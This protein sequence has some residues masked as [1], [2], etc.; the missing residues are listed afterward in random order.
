[1]VSSPLQLIINLNP[2]IHYEA[3]PL[4]IEYGSVTIMDVELPQ[5][6]IPLPTPRN[7]PLII[8]LLVRKE[9]AKK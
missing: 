3:N 5:L 9:I 2:E 4:E 7:L 8:E 1:M 6:T